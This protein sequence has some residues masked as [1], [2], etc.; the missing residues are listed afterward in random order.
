MEHRLSLP[1]EMVLL[2]AN[3]LRLKYRS[4]TE[5]YSVGSIFIDLLLKRKIELDTKGKV[6][7]VDSDITGVDYLDQ[8]ILVLVKSFRTRKLK[9]WIKYFHFKTRL[10]GKIHNSILQE[11]QKKGAITLGLKVPFLPLR[12][13]TE[14]NQSREQVVKLI[15]SQLIYNRDPDEQTVVLLYL[16][17]ETGLL[18]GYFN[19]KERAEI[20]DRINGQK[21][22]LSIDINSIRRI[23]KAIQD[24]TACLASLGGALVTP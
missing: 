6:V 16:L 11:L 8:V 1:E 9:A 14:I 22:Q 24:I 10:R 7:V 13:I 12:K 15:H 19:S 3:H 21:D 2:G 23:E 17:K 4:Y 5:T 20:M 18:K